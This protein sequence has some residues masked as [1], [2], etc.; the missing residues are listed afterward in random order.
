[1]TTTEERVDSPEREIGRARDR[2]RPHAGPSIDRD[3]AQQDQQDHADQ[4][5]NAQAAESRTLAWRRLGG[6]GGIDDGFVS[7]G[8]ARRD[9]APTHW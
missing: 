8:F 7:I 9:L 1:M 3:R 5:S 2:A 4:Y 6:T